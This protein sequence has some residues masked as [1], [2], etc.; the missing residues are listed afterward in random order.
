MLVS[1][2]LD[3]NTGVRSAQA[4]LRQS[5]ALRDGAAAALLPTLDAS[6]SAQ[7]STGGNTTGNAFSAGA[8]AA[9]GPDVSGGL[10][11]ALA[12]RD[13]VALSS[14]ATLGDAQVQV[15]AEVALNYVT[16][17]TAQ[18]R[19]A[20]A[21]DNL[22]TQVETLQIAQWRE[23]AG[24][25]TT[26]E[27]EQ[28]RASAEQTRALVPA[29][30]KTIVQT[31]HA[32]AVLVGQPPLAKVGDGP[33]S[34]DE[35]NALIAADAA[36]KA[37][38][39]P[40]ASLA[41]SIPAD[42]LRQRADVRAAEH[43]VTAARANVA[44]AQAQRWPSFNLGGSVGLNALTLGTLT[45]GASVVSSL[46]ASISV[47]L[48]DGG[49]ARAQVRAQSAA[50]DQANESWRAA[51]LGALRDVEDAL[52][53]LR[54]DRQRLASLS[55]AADAA[56]AAAQ[57][58]RQRY[59]GGLVDFQVV[60]ETQRTQLSAQDALASARADVSADHVRLFRALGGGWSD[61]TPTASATT[62]G[63]TTP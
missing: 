51:I 39:Q 11:S 17:R 47:P 54:S 9:W 42:T 36:V 56:S 33:I 60:L 58:A 31:R 20:I 2:A 37:V 48:F 14:A 8:Q 21:R 27:V 22:A 16:L 63:T 28:A 62:R 25:T 10:R 3:A 15:A 61:A 30:E 29:L 5:Q 1:R 7:R 49:A 34:L 55:S 43:Q 12:A 4:A 6:F 38:P 24:L 41:L 26:L 40:S 19:L 35:P 45:N 52:V 44:Q 23:E 59:S 53:A 13:A 57:L 46:L 18:A 50:L 32:L